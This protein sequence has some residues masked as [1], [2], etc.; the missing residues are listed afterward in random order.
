MMLGDFDITEEL[1]DRAPAHL[2]DTNVIMALRNLCQ[3]LGLKDSWHH[4]FPPWEILH[5]LCKHKQAI[6]NVQT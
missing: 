1:I 2:D 3:C 4:A 5:L 6:Y